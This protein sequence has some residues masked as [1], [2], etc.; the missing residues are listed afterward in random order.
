M[1]RWCKAMQPRVAIRE[2]FLERLKNQAMKL[3]L[4][5]LLYGKIESSG[6]VNLAQ[7]T[8]VH[9]L[10]ICNFSGRYGSK[11][12]AVKKMLVQTFNDPKAEEE[13]MKEV[14]IMSSLR[15]PNLLLFMGACTKSG[16]MTMVTELMSK[17]SLYDLLKTSEGKSL[18]MR[19]RMEMAKDTAQVFFILFIH[20]EFSQGM[21]WLHTCMNP[22]ILHLDLKTSNILVDENY[23]VKVA[24]FGLSQIKKGEIKEKVIIFLINR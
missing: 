12:V 3:T 13:F 21:N 17:G 22:P 7:F 15:H 5:K 2:L 14:K 20:T 8:E 1:P 23:H 4:K 16:E 24:D 18:P 19:K 6:E 10:V 11:D 9:I